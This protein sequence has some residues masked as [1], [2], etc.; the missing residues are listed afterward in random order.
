MNM[1]G[2]V[3]KIAGSVYKALID[4]DQAQILQILRHV[5]ILYAMNTALMTLSEFL[6]GKCAVMWRERLTNRA[7]VV[8]FQENAFGQVSHVDNSDQRITS[9]IEKLC[10]TISLVLLKASGSPLKILFYGYLTSTYTGILAVALVVGFFCCSIVLQKA[11]A[12]PLAHV[13]QQVEQAE[14]NFRAGHMRMKEQST[15]IALQQDQSAEKMAVGKLL[16]EALRAQ[17]AAVWKRSAV[18]GVTK[19]IDYTGS[20]LNY[21]LVSFAILFGRKGGDDGGTRAEFVSNASFFTL[22]FIFSLTELVDLGEYVSEML[23]LISRIYGLFDAIEEVA[24]VNRQRETTQIGSSS[25]QELIPTGML[26]MHIGSG[27]FCTCIYVEI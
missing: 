22:T 14:G 5:A 21:A 13:L 6:R 26:C 20:I 4:L 8:Y 24:S 25:M 3:G 12:L 10:S 9:E 15:D 11:V 19:C 1:Y 17:N 2:A 16:Q 7:H 18:V 27:V 23:A